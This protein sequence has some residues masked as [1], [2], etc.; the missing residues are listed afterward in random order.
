MLG[1]LL[2]LVE[3]EFE[4]GIGWVGTEIWLGWAGDLVGLM[5]CIIGDL[6][7]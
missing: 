6:V 2:H 7:G 1:C 5:I 4:F 3:F